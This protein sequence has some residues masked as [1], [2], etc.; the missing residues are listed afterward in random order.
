MKNLLFILLFVSTAVFGF[1]E[2]GEYEEEIRDQKNEKES[3]QN[4]LKNTQKEEQIDLNQIQ[5][6]YLKRSNS[7][8]QQPQKK[9]IE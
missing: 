2:Y 8:K 1:E 5:D 4:K 6:G 9:E 3:N 7:N